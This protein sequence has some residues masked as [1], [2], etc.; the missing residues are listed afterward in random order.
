MAVSWPPGFPSPLRDDY[1][2]EQLDLNL[3]TPFAQGARVRPLFTDG[4]D[5]FS[6]SVLLSAAQWAYV[7]GWHQHALARGSAWFTMP[8]LAAGTLETREVRLLGPLSFQPVGYRS[9]RVSMSL[10]T[11]AGTAMSADFWEAFSAFPDPDTAGRDLQAL[12]DFVNSGG[13]E[14]EPL[15]LQFVDDGGDD[16]LFGPDGDSLDFIT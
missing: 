11:R 1:R 6:V 4:P 8:I 5:T 15:T 7:Q 14:S 3:R 10:E 9:V 16:L 2:Y 13:G 12:E